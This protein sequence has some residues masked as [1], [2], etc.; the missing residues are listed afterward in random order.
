MC[1][2][3][4]RLPANCRSGSWSPVSIAISP[5]SNGCLTR[6]RRPARSTSDGD[7]SI[8]GGRDNPRR[9]AMTWTQAL[10]IAD[11]Q[12]AQWQRDGVGPAE[13]L[14]ALRNEQPTRMEPI[15]S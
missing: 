1:G 4:S 7:W 6:M 3:I 11:R 2:A 14:M 8:G 15:A 10:R 13:A 12:I 9:P 5:T